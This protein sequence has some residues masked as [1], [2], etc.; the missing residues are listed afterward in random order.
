MAV[1]HSSQNSIVRDRLTICV[2]MG[3]QASSIFLRV[4]VVM[5]SNSQ[6][7]FFM[8]IITV[9]TS[10]SV[11]G[12]KDANLGVSCCAGLYVL[13]KFS[14]IFS[15]LDRKNLA[16]SSTSSL[17]VLLGGKRFCVVLP[18]SLL[19]NPPGKFSFP[20]RQVLTFPGMAQLLRQPVQFLGEE[21]V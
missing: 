19:T 9:C 14:L 12:H 17:S 5:M 2:M 10:I 21:A 15:I 16:K 8:F 4:P 1:F 18:V 7:L 3:R 13:M 20:G 6:C 11:N